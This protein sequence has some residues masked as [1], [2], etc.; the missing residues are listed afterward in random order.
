MNE[1]F[2]I[3]Q[4]SLLNFDA[5]SVDFW[6]VRTASKIKTTIY[7]SLKDK[8]TIFFTNNIF[9]YYFE[10]RSSSAAVLADYI[11]EQQHNI[12]PPARN[13]E[14]LTANQH[15]ECSVEQSK[16]FKCDCKRWHKSQI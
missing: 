6:S 3:N 9:V 16:V 1:T 14:G 4:K 13:D 7:T 10:L 5:N 8:L 11:V 12:E 2:F 15:F